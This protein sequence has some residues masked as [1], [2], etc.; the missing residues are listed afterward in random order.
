VAGLN[1]IG[2]TGGFGFFSATLDDRI[3]FHEMVQDLGAILIG[4]LNVGCEFW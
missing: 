3:D 4:E 1:E 2:V